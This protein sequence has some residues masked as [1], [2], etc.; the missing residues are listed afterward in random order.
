MGFSVITSKKPVISINATLFVQVINF[1]IIVFILN[2][3]LFKPI[4]KSLAERDNLIEGSKVRAIELKQKGEEKLIEYNRALDQARLKASEGQV[5][6]RKEAM[7]AAE[8]MIQSAMAEEQ[9][10]IAQIRDEIK[11]EAEKAHI[12]LK[13]QAENICNHV[14]LKILGRTI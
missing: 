2:K 7:A 1:L 14:T 3:I 10:I 9:K 12:E 13:A 5:E 4:L 6:I 8:T 11:V